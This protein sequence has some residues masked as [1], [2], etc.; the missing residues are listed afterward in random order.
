M[1]TMPISAKF[2]WSETNNYLHIDV[3]VPTARPAAAAPVPSVKAAIDVTVSPVYIKTS[4]P[5]Y[6]FEADLLHEID[7]ASPETTTKVTRG[8]V[9]LCLKKRQPGL[10]DNFDVVNLSKAEL[11]ERRQ[12]S[13]AR[14]RERQEKIRGARTA[15]RQ[16]NEKLGQEQQ[17]Q[18]DKD[19]R[20]WIT[21]S[22]DEQKRLAEHEIYAEPFDVSVKSSKNSPDEG[23]GMV[24]ESCNKKTSTA[25]KDGQAHRLGLHPQVEEWDEGSACE[26]DV[27]VGHTGTSSSTASSTDSYTAC[28]PR[29]PNRVVVSFTPKSDMTRPARQ[30][31]IP[32][33]P[34][35]IQQRDEA[36]VH[37]STTNNN[38]ENK[39]FRKEEEN[40]EWLKK[41][42]DAFMEREDLQAAIYAYDCALKIAEDTGCMANA[43]LCFLRLG[44]LD[45]CVDLCNRAVQGIMSK[46]KVPEGHVQ[47]PLSLQDART[48]TVLHVRR[49]V[50]ELWGGHIDRSIISLEAA[51]VSA[52]NLHMDERS[53]LVD[54]LSEI[55]KTKSLLQKKIPVDF[56]LAKCLSQETVVECNAEEHRQED[57]RVGRLRKVVASYTHLL[58]GEATTVVQSEQHSSSSACHS[59]PVPGLCQAVILANRCAALI[60]LKEFPSALAGTC[61]CC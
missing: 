10:W 50:A 15:L 20:E 59:Q 18:A 46:C 1:R 49:G 27:Q 61:I 53:S 52:A 42:G 22:K 3:T 5:P 48:V 9:T 4:C 21:K 6:L 43:G 11:T 28:P 33:H 37:R 12:T 2:R 58:S 55:K 45:Q 44:K 38:K 47:P 16:A 41:K 31:N 39:S 8:L 30:T 34:D 51:I 56:D 7:D 25:A 60:Q 14:A 24:M 54:D 13:L 17:W 40:P 29:V 32:P 35:R 19:H 36:A 57:G 23:G 26:T